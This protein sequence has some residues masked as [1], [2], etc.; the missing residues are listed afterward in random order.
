ML[1]TFTFP[2]TRDRF[3]ASLGSSGLK[4][5]PADG[6][7]L[8][9]GHY[10][11][12]ERLGQYC[13]RYEEGRP[14]LEPDVVEV[15]IATSPPVERPRLSEAQLWQFHKASALR[16]A[17][18]TEEVEARAAEVLA[19]LS[20]GESVSSVM[21]ATGL[22]RGMI[23]KLAAG[24]TFL[25]PCGREASHRGACSERYELTP[26]RLAAQEKARA[27]TMS[28]EEREQARQRATAMQ[29]SFTPA[30]RSERAKRMHASRSPA[31]RSAICKKSA[32]VRLQRKAR[33]EMAAQEEGIGLGYNRVKFSVGRG[34]L[35][36]QAA[37]IDAEQLADPE[38]KFLVSLTLLVERFM[39]RNDAILEVE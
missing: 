6:S 16:W 11:A 14:D 37:G 19:L 5:S 27:R 15:E 20:Q 1:K 32:A 3:V 9:P 8:R 4:E 34:A 39:D 7:I 30:E 2:S 31:A 18:H 23:K 28:P 29:A 22:S 13:V 24:R 21:A 36:I 10:R 12:F 25:C 35:T 33:L 38:R 17:A 26:A